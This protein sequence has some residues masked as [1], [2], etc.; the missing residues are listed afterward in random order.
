MDCRFHDSDIGQ[1]PS[2]EGP[3]D[4]ESISNGLVFIQD[5]HCAANGTDAEKGKRKQEEDPSVEARKRLRLD[6]VCNTNKTAPTTILSPPTPTSLP[7]PSLALFRKS[8]RPPAKKYTRP[9]TKKVFESLK[10]TPEEWVRLECEAKA[11]MLDTSHPDRQSCVG[12]RANSPTNDTK[13]SLYKTV[14]RFL[15]S[16]I[17][18]RFFGGGVGEEIVDVGKRWIYPRDE[19]A[20]I[21]LLT[22]LMRR[23]V[24]N[25]RQ[26]QYARRTRAAVQEQQRVQ[27]RGQSPFQDDTCSDLPAQVLDQLGERTALHGKIEV[28]YISNERELFHQHAIEDIPPDYGK[29]HDFILAECS[30]HRSADSLESL[31]IHIHGPYKLE[32]VDGD[33]WNT[34]RDDIRS[35]AWTADGP[36]KVIVECD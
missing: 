8:T 26:R 1:P 11:Y 15:E 2:Y 33:N 29:L 21:I 14:Q 22:P 18:A 34:L 24:T 5:V 17:G 7:T 23:M 12:N 20:L 3:A 13:I 36:I 25:E 6:S 19:T 9:P 10:L 31:K 30:H 35:A 28:F 32:L 16:D 4:R 27:S